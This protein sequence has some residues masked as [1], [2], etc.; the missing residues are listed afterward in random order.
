MLKTNREPNLTMVNEWLAR[1][2]DEEIKVLRTWSRMN[3]SGQLRAPWIQS[4]I[5]IFRT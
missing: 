4:M 5:C 2:Y 3:Q 1:L